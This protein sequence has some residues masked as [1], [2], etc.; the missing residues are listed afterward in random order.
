MSKIKCIIILLFMSL[1]VFLI[2]NSTN[3]AV[4]VNRNIYSNNGS[5]KFTFTGLELDMTHEYEYGFTVTA[6]TEVEDWFLITEYTESTAVVDLLTT[7]REIREVINA[8]DTGYITI[9]DKTADSIVLEPYGVDLKIPYLRVTNYTVI[10]N[11]KEF[12]TGETETINVAIRNTNNSTAY[13]QYEKIT[14]Q[15]IVDKYNEIK[16]QNGDMTE[17]ESMLTTTAPMNN[18][19]T[20]EYWNGYSLDGLNGFGRP[21]SPIS[22]P[23]EGLY[24]LWVY[25][26]GNNIKNVY[27]YILVDNLD[28]EVSNN[29]QQNQS[30]VN[31]NTGTSNQQNQSNVDNNTGIS[32]KQN[33]STVGNDN[34]TATMKLPEAGVSTIISIILFVTIICTIGLYMKNRQYKDIK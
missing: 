21:E 19:S 30:N 7:T 28:A 24:Y 25:F 9:K 1:M 2:P 22:A 34:T 29:N 16:S 6:A 18:W 12:G 15:N 4:D 23:D 10:E 11:G 13:Y 14:D 27:G 32:G 20:W 26:S 5:M 8:T 31:N 3:A 17:L 33:T